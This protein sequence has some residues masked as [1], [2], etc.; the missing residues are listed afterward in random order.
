[1]TKRLYKSPEKKL[2]GVCSGIAE[3]FTIDPTI[4][5]LIWI[6]ATCASAGMGIIAYIICAFIMPDRP[7]SAADWDTMKRANDFS[8]Q[9]KEFNSHFEK[10]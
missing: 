8:E 4:V 10:K 9:D 5:R 3:Y 6:V 2:C 7:S 1:M